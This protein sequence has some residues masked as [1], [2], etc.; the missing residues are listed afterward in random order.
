M[1]IHDVRNN[2]LQKIIEDIFD[3]PGEYIDESLIT[4]LKREVR[5]STFICPAC[6]A[7]LL[8]LGDE[9]ESGV[10]IPA[11]TSMN[12]YNLEFEGANIEPV[13]WQFSDVVQ[14]LENENFEG[15]IVNPH[16]D[17]FFISQDVIRDALDM[18]TSFTRYYKKKSEF[19]DDELM[20]IFEN[21]NADID[22]YLTG[23]DFSFEHLIHKLSKRDLFTL[24]S[25]ADDFTSKILRYEDIS[26]DGF[27]TVNEFNGEY[28]L[29]FSSPE[30][31][32]PV[33]KYY[34]NNQRRLYAFPTTLELMAKYVLELDLDGLILNYGSHSFRIS[35]EILLVY[36]NDIAEITRHEIQHDLSDYLFNL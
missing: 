10:A 2:H 18:M 16:I 32:I 11:F 7:G 19:G 9:G 23:S 36:I 25:S 30:H 22:E 13:A 1:N 27:L 26:S 8:L 24:V 15:I 21:E 17:N 3:F 6:G 29:I 5:F 14:Y 35:R 34:E 4:D 31:M 20:K 12:E 33:K 28:C